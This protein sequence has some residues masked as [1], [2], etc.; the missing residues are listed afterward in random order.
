MAAT[1]NRQAQAKRFRDALIRFMD[2]TSATPVMVAEI[3]GKPVSTVYKWIAGQ[4]SPP[5]KLQ[6]ELAHRF[7]WNA[8]ELFSKNAFLEKILHQD[9]LSLEALNY[10]Y[11]SLADRLLA[12]HLVAVGATVAM[13]YLMDHGLPGLALFAGEVKENELLYFRVKL[14]LTEPVMSGSHLRVTG[15]QAQ[16]LQLCLFD[17]NNVVHGP[18][19]TLNQTGLNFYLHVLKGYRK[20]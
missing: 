15:T 13:R 6:R 18:W 11:I 10:L 7:N 4:Q 9:F 5:A 12:G 17:A 1:T 2:T 3:A 20:P 16:G 8:D 14:E 19:Q